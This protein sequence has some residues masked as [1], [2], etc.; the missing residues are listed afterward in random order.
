MSGKN[1]LTGHRWGYELNKDVAFR[2][3]GIGHKLTLG[4]G[5]LAAVT[6]LVV[7][8]AIVAGRSA[9]HDIQTTESVHGPAA[10]AS[11]QAQANLL[12]MQLHIRGYLVLSDQQDIEQYRIARQA[13][14]QSLAS[15]QAMARHWPEADRQAVAALTAK[16]ERWI[17]LPPQ[18]FELH[19]NVLRN[20][21]ALRLVRV[22]MQA[23][24]VQVM[25]AID[26]T[27]GIQEKRGS[28]PRN[29]ELLA[30]LLGF[31]TS[32]DSMV[33]NLMAHAVSGELNFKQAYGAQLI[34]N[35]AIWDALSGKR[36]L[37]LPEQRERLDTIARLRAE[38]GE[39]WLRIA[40]ILDGEHA[41]ED[42]YLY[43]TEFVPQAQALLGLLGK[44]T[45]RQ[46]AELRTGLARARDSLAG[47]R[48]QTIIGG[49]AAV[50]FSLVLAFLFR[51]N[52]V[53]P[54]RRLTIV[55]EQ[56]AAGDHD[57]RAEVESRDEIGKLGASINIM[58]QRLAQTIA[59]L[60]T[61]LAEAQRARDAAEAANRGKNRFLANVSHE[62]RTPLNAILGHAQML[63]RDETLQ[64]R[65]RSGVNVIRQSGEHLL[66]FINDL[67]DFAR[68]EAGKQEPQPND[69]QLARFLR[70]ITDLTGMKALHKGL[71]F[72]CEAAPDVPQWVWADER[73]LRQVL[74]HLLSNAVRFTER[75]EVSLHV[76][77]P[78]AGRLRFEV[79]DTGIGIGPEQLETIFELFEQAEERQRL[80]GAGL[81]LTISR[82]C[83]RLM[84]SEI[85]VE[86][87][88]G[89][90]S[91]FWFELD[92]QASGVE[93]VAASASAAPDR[94]DAAAASTPEE[95]PLVA[96]PAHE[97]AILHYLARLGSMIEIVERADYLAGLDERYIPFA[98][99]LRQ[100]AGGYHSKAVL[101]M[102]EHYMEGSPPA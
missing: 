59:S 63:S 22:E 18:L 99:R 42:M 29:R 16:Y 33:T 13:F 78:A 11:A 14:E 101:Q 86:S 61:V 8:L 46:Q 83:V 38:I 56:V 28:S 25:D 64:E 30:D 9:T 85:Q 73:R 58:T 92:A 66:T 71:K 26:A 23:L 96:P 47:A 69:I 2:P 6:L 37:L 12:K 20:R 40:G 80:G 51:R 90:G 98:D 60:K 27:I 65:Q 95:R 48:L 31:Q 1:G 50:V 72:R 52:I 55:A 5:A 49:V 7:A 4:F 39:L 36:A 35:T 82:Q 57:A 54:V 87:R 70:L 79:R 94:A 21:P 74:L 34:T 44:V 81:G 89:E 32:F 100:L 93:A 97:M 53:N 19:D 62:L 91:R 76:S 102:V 75:G 68:I 3:L 24:R 41:Y 17:K 10:L 88:V 77:C 45:E 15:L 43:R 84:G 67:L